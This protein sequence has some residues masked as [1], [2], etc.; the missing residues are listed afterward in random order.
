MKIAGDNK[1]DNPVW[2]SLNETHA[3]FSL[4]YNCLKCYEPD[5]CPFGGYEDHSF[6]ANEIDSYSEL[7]DNFY[8]VGE[9]P[10]F[11]H[12]LV[13]KKELICLQMLVDHP[14][15]VVVT[16]EII[17][18]NN[19][20]EKDLFDLVNLVQPGYFRSKTSKLGDYYGIFEQG[21]LVSV[22]GERMKMNNFTEVSAV[23]T[24]PNH[25][26]KGYAKQLIAYTVNKIF[27]QNKIPFLHVAQ[28]NTNAIQLY[29]K[30]G[31]VTRKKISFWNFE[32]SSHVRK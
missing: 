13:L 28:S 22:T 30:L 24:H 15:N 18:L 1:L 23:V 6:I 5:Y 31:F 16:D 27:N 20:F 25:T 9:R 11:S 10:A 3:N 14:T 12:N 19:R 7:I 4:N 29:Q 8:I 21:I 2:H 26:G 32:K 17:Q